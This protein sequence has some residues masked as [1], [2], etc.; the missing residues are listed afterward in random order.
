MSLARLPETVARLVEYAGSHRVVIW[1]E[2]AAGGRPAEDYLESSEVSDEEYLHLEELWKL[3]ANR[4]FFAHKA[5]QPLKGLDLMELKFRHARLLIRPHGRY[6]IL[7]R[8]GTKQGRR[9]AKH[10]LKAARKA[11]EEMA[12]W[13]D[14]QEE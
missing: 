14:M 3:L 8:G 12:H 9:L 1:A 7:V 6:V 10:E 4:P 11:G 5:Y 2:T 13:L